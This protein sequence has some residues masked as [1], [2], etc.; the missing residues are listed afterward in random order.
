MSPVKS[1]LKKPKK[2]EENN[3]LTSKPQL[4][5]RRKKET[6]STRRDLNEVQ[7][8]AEITAKQN[9]SSQSSVSTHSLFDQTINI[10]DLNNSHRIT[11]N[12]SRPS[13]LQYYIKPYRGEPQLPTNTNKQRSKSLPQQ[14]KRTEQSDR[15]HHVSWSPMKDYFH[16]G[17]ENT[18]QT[19]SEKYLIV[20]FIFYLFIIIIFSKKTF[21]NK[22]GSSS[23]SFN[24]SLSLSNPCLQNIS[25]MTPISIDHQPSEFLSTNLS[26]ISPNRE[27]K[28]R[29]SKSHLPNLRYYQKK[30]HNETMKH[31]DQLLERMRTT[32]QQL[33]TL[34]QLWMKNTSQ[35]SSV[36]N[37]YSFYQEI[38][39]N[40][41]KEFS[42]VDFR[43][44]MIEDRIRY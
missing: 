1:I 13:R 41:K 10:F 19:P 14:L 9:S 43:L 4:R 2:K 30:E 44:K 21:S 27:D 37:K 39:N 23:L 40:Y 42:M 20:F 18:R 34:S 7:H 22:F 12:S 38:L 24:P 25:S 17:K 8:L 31:Y 3:I 26:D 5:S 33:Q 29:I 16:Y 11:S 36:S 15:K 32:D 35:K 6:S 28:D